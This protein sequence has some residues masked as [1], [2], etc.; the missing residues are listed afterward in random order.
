MLRPNCI[1]IALIVFLVLPSVRA[2]SEGRQDREAHAE[3]QTP[4]PQ[5]LTPPVQDPAQLVTPAQTASSPS[6]IAKIVADFGTDQKA[7]WTSPFHVNRDNAKWWL[8]F[9]LGTATLIATD[10]TTEKAIPYSVS[11]TAY[12]TDVSRIGQEYVTLPIAAGLYWY[13]RAGNHPKAR[14]VGVLGAE[15]LLDSEILVTIL[16]VAGG[17]ER[18]NVVG[19]NG[20]FFKGKGLSSGF[21]SGHAI[22]TWT[23]AAVISHEYGPSKIVPIV[24][25]GIATAVSVARFTGQFHYASDILAGGAMG[26]FIGR[27]VWD[28][29]QDPAIHKRYG[30]VSR[31]MPSRFSPVIAKHTQGVNL[32]WVK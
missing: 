12:S 17:R 27:Y 7:I 9:G 3:A 15:A 6:T 5:T 22:E 30:A 23:F 20:R 1:S 32:S 8:I 18:P 26:W 11:Q 2:F 24:T 29:H 4:A 25:Y 16:K 19:G 31:L 10:R 21:P 28:R 13:G 14:E